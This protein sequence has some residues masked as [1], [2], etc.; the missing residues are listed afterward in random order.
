MSCTGRYRRLDVLAR[1]CSLSCGID[2]KLECPTTGGLAVRKV[3]ERRENRTSAAPLA[4]RVVLLIMIFL[5]GFKVRPSRGDVEIHV[6]YQ[7]QVGLK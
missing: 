2:R 4:I 1:T 5:G 6:G 3:G 7:G